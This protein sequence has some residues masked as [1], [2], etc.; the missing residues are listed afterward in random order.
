MQ[1]DAMLV[2]AL[3][4]YNSLWPLPYPMNEE[5]GNIEMK[6]IKRSKDQRIKVSRVFFVRTP[7]SFMKKDKWIKFVPKTHSFLPRLSIHAIFHQLGIHDVVRE[8]LF[9]DYL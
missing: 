3:L 1:C 2:S 5:D 7:P 9:L 8:F 4:R 6:R